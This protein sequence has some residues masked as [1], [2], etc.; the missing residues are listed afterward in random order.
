M[1]AS[2]RI[3]RKNKADLLRADPLSVSSSKGLMQGLM[4]C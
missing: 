3:I 1:C 4:H 2:V